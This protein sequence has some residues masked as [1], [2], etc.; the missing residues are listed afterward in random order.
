MTNVEALTALYIA[1]GGDAADIDPNATNADIIYAIAGQDAIAPVTVAAAS[2]A[3]DFW[4]TTAAEMQSDISIANGEITGTLL[5]LFDGQL[6]TDWGAGNFLALSFADADITNKT[7]EVGL[8]PS[9]GSGFVKL[10][11]DKLGV[12]KIT[13][14]DTQVFKVITTDDNGMKKIQT[15]SLSKLVCNQS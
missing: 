15:Y 10:D 13:D 2:A 3:T 8:V 12:F 6:V 14:K 5:Y 7:V 4:G 9:A 11:P 1:H